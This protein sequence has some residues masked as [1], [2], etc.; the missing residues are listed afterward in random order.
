MPSDE[1]GENEPTMVTF[2]DIAR[3][4]VRLGYAESLTRQGVRHL[5][6][7]DPKWPVPQE[8]WIKL[9]NAWVMPWPPI[10][11]Y[12]SEHEFTGRGPDKQPRRRPET[13][14]TEE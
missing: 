4:A 10:K 9:G 14:P 6:D 13:E 12:L 5:A 3:L 1:K 11:Q 2:T 8:E 7:T